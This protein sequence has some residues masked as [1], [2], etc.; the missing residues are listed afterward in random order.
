MTQDNNVMALP[1]QPADM[2]TFIQE[3]ITRSVQEGLDDRAVL[4]AVHDYTCYWLM[5]TEQ[6][7]PSEPLPIES[8]KRYN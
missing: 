2:L 1:R 7:D 6:D 8:D 3:C 4:E 5:A